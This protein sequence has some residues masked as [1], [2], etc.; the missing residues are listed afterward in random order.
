MYL[1]YTVPPSL[2]ANVL[3]AEVTLL[4][5]G[6]AQSLAQVAGISCPK[7]PTGYVV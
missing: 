6:V 7:D 5:A 1:T 4:P 2:T 3:V